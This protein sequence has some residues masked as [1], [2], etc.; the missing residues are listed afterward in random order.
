LAAETIVLSP[1]FHLELLEQS[2]QSLKR[3]L[4]LAPPSAVGKLAEA[5]R[6]LVQIWKK[7][8][9]AESAASRFTEASHAYSKTLALDPGQTA[10]MLNHAIVLFNLALTERN[11]M[12]ATEAEALLKKLIAA[13]D[14][15]EKP[16]YYLGLVQE[17]TGRKP[18][19]ILSWQQAAALHPDSNQA[20][21]ARTKL[22]V[23]EKA[24]L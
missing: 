2:E 14:H 6:H 16:F 22:Q 9:A 24:E 4:K 15:G 12:R 21:Q 3:A 10:V 5:R 19:A 8:A 11:E 18:D 17:A 20:A 1:A 23:A 7:K 13:P